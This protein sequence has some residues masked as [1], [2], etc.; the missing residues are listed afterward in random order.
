M[1]QT[2]IPKGP[3]VPLEVNQGGLLIITIIPFREEHFMNS[4]Y[5]DSFATDFELKS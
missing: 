5:K 3:R 1:K 4:P 2:H